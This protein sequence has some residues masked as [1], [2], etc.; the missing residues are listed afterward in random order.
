MIHDCLI[1]SGGV[2]PG[3]DLFGVHSSH[4]L[5]ILSARFLTRLK[6]HVL[7]SLL[8][9]E[10]VF[11]QASNCSGTGLLSLSDVHLLVH[12]LKS[13]TTR[14]LLLFRYPSAR[15]LEVM[16][17]CVLLQLLDRAKED[18][19]V[20]GAFRGF[21]TQNNLKHLHRK[22][23]LILVS[24]ISIALGGLLPVSSS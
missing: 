21:F 5:S 22:T 23:S 6:F 19:R 10:D 7:L 9:D 17:A 8:N 11:G 14:V 15:L 13:M 18:H 12:F 3:E 2:W 20:R 1:A 16:T 4:L 24:Q